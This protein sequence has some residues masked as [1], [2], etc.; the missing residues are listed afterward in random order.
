M[1]SFSIKQYD[2]SNVKTVL[3]TRFANYSFPKEIQQVEITDFYQCE[4]LMTDLKIMFD[5]AY[6]IYRSRISDLKSNKSQED[7]LHIPLSKK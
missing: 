3:E 1:D 4:N 7:K 6:E 2:I 5:G